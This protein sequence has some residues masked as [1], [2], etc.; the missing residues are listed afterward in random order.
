MFEDIQEN[1]AETPMLVTLLPIVIA[2]RPGKSLVMRSGRL[3]TNCLRVTTVS[4]FILQW[5]HQD[6]N[7][8]PRDYES[9]RTLWL[10]IITLLLLHF[11]RA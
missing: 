8:G 3:T 7:L 11:R 5:A 4:G 1:D 9:T 10:V 6:S 2:T